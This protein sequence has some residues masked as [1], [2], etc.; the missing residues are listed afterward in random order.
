MSIDPQA[1][2]IRVVAFD[3]SL[4][5]LGVACGNIY[6]AEDNKVVVTTATTY[7]IDELLGKFPDE[8]LLTK[9]T[10]L[11]DKVKT[12]AVK[13]ITEFNPHFVVAEKPIFKMNP[14]TYANQ[15][16]GVCALRI[17]TLECSKNPV[18]ELIYDVEFFHPGHVKDTLGVAGNNGDKNLITQGLLE[19][20]KTGQLVYLD[21]EHHPDKLDDHANDAVTMLLTK[22]ATLY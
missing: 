2:T 9:R 8:A 15:W 1:D 5:N 12:L 14:E 16:E 19:K 13:I 20:I 22:A 4:K 7:Y 3:T 17:A 6:L 11:V 10:Q 18:L 21:E